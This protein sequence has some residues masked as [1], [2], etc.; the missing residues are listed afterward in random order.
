MSK[1]KVSLKVVKCFIGQTQ[2]AKE[3]YQY[4][5]KCAQQFNK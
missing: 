2:V 1:S 4:F 3:K 5:I